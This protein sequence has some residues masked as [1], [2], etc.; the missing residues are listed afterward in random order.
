MRHTNVSLNTLIM[1]VNKVNNQKPAARVV[2]GSALQTDEG[3]FLFTPYQQRS[4]EADPWTPLAVHAHGYLKRTER[5][6]QLRVT[7]PLAATSAPAREIMNIACRLC[8]EAIRKG[9]GQ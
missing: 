5:V 2:K 7:L 6:M 3:D 4:P 8:M 9:G 1:K